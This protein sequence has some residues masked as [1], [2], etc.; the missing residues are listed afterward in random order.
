MP[1]IHFLSEVGANEY[2]LRYVLVD[3]EPHISVFRVQ[4]SLEHTDMTNMVDYEVLCGICRRS[5]DSANESRH[6]RLY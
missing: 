3:V 2:V 6:S 5:L 4:S 1:S